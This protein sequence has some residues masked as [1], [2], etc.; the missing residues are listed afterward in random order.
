MSCNMAFTNEKT[1]GRRSELIQGVIDE[2]KEAGEDLTQ[3][4]EVDSH[5]KTFREYWGADEN[6]DEEGRREIR[7]I[8]ERSVSEVAKRERPGRRRSSDLF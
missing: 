5:K 3:E 8:F 7:E 6:M 1:G 2:M 4:R